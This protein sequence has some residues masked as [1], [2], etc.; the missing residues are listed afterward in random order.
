MVFVENLDGW[1]WRA[2]WKFLNSLKIFINSMFFIKKEKNKGGRDA[3]C[4]PAPA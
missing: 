1:D 2:Q 4:A 3:S